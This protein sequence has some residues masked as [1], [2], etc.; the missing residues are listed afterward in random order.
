MKAI[1][2]K[3]RIEWECC[4][5]G[6]AV[7]LFHLW[8]VPAVARGGVF[9]KDNLAFDFDIGRF[10]SLWGVSPFQI[11]QNA[12]YYAVR[13]PLV[14]LLRLVGLPLVSAG[15]EPHVV[16][17]GI[18]AVCA[19][20]SSV[21]M[22]RIARAL[23]VDRGLAFVLT[24]MWTFSTASL[25]LGVLPEAYSLALVALSW[26]MLLAIRWTQGHEPAL[27]VRI[28]AAVVNLGITITNVVLSGLVEL[29]CRLAR[30][31]VRK[32]VLGTAAFSVAVVAIGLALSIASFRIW[33][34]QN[35]DTSGRAVK[36]LYWSASSA[37]GDTRRQS[38]AEV[39]WTFGAIASVA[40][41]VA[42]YPSG[43]PDD[44]Y[45][46]D[47][48]ARNYG[49]A[50]WIAVL[51]WL[52]L[53][54]LGAMAAARDREM[55]AFWIIAGSWIATNIALHSYWQFRQTVFLYAAHSHIAFFVFVVAGARWA[56]NRHPKGGMTYGAVAG[57]V[58]LL[59]IANNMQLYLALPRLS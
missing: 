15:L 12:S 18:A 42:P 51:G 36:Q 26:Q 6:L 31:P 55:R 45:L 35:V 49:V 56:Q 29:V 39:A 8:H 24:A 1:G 52:G 53:L 10:V 40:P 11:E 58:T 57:L 38:P 2:G 32:A 30:Q 5:I 4:V 27:A 19:A 23:G 22:F 44:P 48:R 28:V 59:L 43:A 37:E 9:L 21:L 41:A 34:V 7:F 47:L 17:C 54:A 13:H 46:Y 16:A 33:P 50:G 25:L 20:L 14:I 3:L